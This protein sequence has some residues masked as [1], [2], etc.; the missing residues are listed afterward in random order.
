M[1]HHHMRLFKLILFV[2]L[3][4]VAPTLFADDVWVELFNGKDLTGWTQKGGKAKFFVQDGC[5]VGETVTNTP[6]SFLCT[7]KDYDN[8]I[9]ELDFKV[10]PRLN[11]GVQFRSQ[12]FDHE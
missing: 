2:T 3:I 9:L 12:C 5:I 10:D 8:F 11:S 6:N 4:A 1:F 7:E